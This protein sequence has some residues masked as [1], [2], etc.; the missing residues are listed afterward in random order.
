VVWTETWFA[1]DALQHLALHLLRE[2]HRRAE[3]SR[4]PLQVLVVGF[5]V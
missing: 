3:F 1:S 5:G 4:D 2:W